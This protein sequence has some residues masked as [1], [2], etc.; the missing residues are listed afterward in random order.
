MKE[1]TIIQMTGFVLK[2]S[3]ARRLQNRKSQQAFRDSQA[4]QVQTLEQSV[5]ELLKQKLA[6][7]RHH[8]AQ[9]FSR[10]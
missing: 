9:L 6:T 2:A 10:V 8:D 1:A 3:L 7:M 4:Q 5:E